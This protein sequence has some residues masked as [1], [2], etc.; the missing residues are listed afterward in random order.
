MCI[1]GSNQNFGLVWLGKKS[2]VQF[3]LG[4]AKIPDL[5]VSKCVLGSDQ[6]FGLGFGWFGLAK[7]K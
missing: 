5:I 1:L 7:K 2:E 3:G 6:N 4:L